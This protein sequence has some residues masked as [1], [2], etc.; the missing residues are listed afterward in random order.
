MNRNSRIRSQ[1]GIRVD[2]TPNVVTVN[3]VIADIPLDVALPFH[4]LWVAADPIKHSTFPDT[5]TGNWVARAFLEFTLNGV[6]VFEMSVNR[7][8][9]PL[10]ELTNAGVGLSGYAPVSNLS[11]QIGA[12]GSQPEM[13]FQSAAAGPGTDKQTL[14]IAPFRLFVVADRVS[15][16]LQTFE[17]HNF[18]NDL[19]FLFGLQIMSHAFP[20]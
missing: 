8:D 4:D 15:M 19:T 12:G 1:F 5:Y 2:G 10:L 16:S 13:V 20:L 6:R 18:A 9:D 7:G 14:R 3:S 17:A 11:H